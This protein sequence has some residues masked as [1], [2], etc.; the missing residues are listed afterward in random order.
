[1]LDRRAASLDVV[2]VQQAAAA[3][4]KTDIVTRHVIAVT[5]VTQFWPLHDASDNGRIRWPWMLS[6]SW[7]SV[8][9][10]P[11]WTA[12]SRK[13]AHSAARS[14]SA[15]LGLYVPTRATILSKCAVQNEKPD[16]ARDPFVFEEQTEDYASVI[17]ESPVRP[18][19]TL[20]LIQA[21]LAPLLPQPSPGDVSIFEDPSGS[22]YNTLT[23]SKRYT[24]SSLIETLSHLVHAKKFGEAYDFLMEIQSSGIAIPNSHLWELPAQ[25]AIISGPSLG[26]EAQIS[27]FT[28]W[29]SLIPPKHLGDPRRRFR[30][31]SKLIF[32]TQHANVPLAIQFSL[33]LA[34]KGYISTISDAIPFVMR[35]APPAVSVQFV[36]DLE[37]ADWDYKALISLGS[38]VPTRRQDALTRSHV[39]AP[40]VEAL[41]RS[42]YLNE[43]ISLL[44]GPDIPPFQL[45]DRTYYLLLSRLRQSNNPDAVKYITHVEKLRKDPAYSKPYDGQVAKNDYQPFEADIDIAL[46]KSVDLK[47][48]ECEVNPHSES[49]IGDALAPELRSLIDAVQSPSTFPTTV[50]LV[51]FIKSYFDT[52]R[53]AAIIRLRRLALQAHVTCA[54][55]FLQAEITYYLTD[56]PPILA[57]KTFADH[58]F[59]SGVP[60]DEVIDALKGSENWPSRDGDDHEHPAYAAMQT[61]AMRKIWPTPAI[62]DLVWQAL[63][64]LAPTDEAVEKLY[65]TLLRFLA[66][67]ADSRLSDTSF[68]RSPYYPTV[69]MAPAVFTPFIQRLIS[70]EHPHR[71]PEFVRDMVRFGIEPNVYHFTQIAGFYASTGDAQ[72]AFIIMDMMDTRYPLHKPEQMTAKR[73]RGTRKGEHL[74]RPDVIFYTSIMRGF[75]QAKSLANALEV[76]RRFKK[77]FV[78]LP[79]QHAPLDEVYADLRRLQQDVQDQVRHA[80]PFTVL[81]TPS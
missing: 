34:S 44:P 15:T 60:Q 1:M 19:S 55:G 73:L 54:T 17:R 40:A 39:R 69:K 47:V 71:V 16:I 76:D 13:I 23:A 14:T 77:R 62:S 72:R 65:Q 22:D 78:Y 21:T 66:V 26:M 61:K 48:L 31:T 80:S 36:K 75:V 38:E 41:A 51:P 33:M 64:K 18:P 46:S 32:Q 35:F 58:L 67:N 7:H 30:R 45:P 81:G 6:A 52:G 5:N 59:L 8:G 50:K 12:I 43:A 28:T 42:N 27:R 25:A 37:K 4:A 9:H 56:G 29:F 57:I 3:D 63:V 74:L 10:Q 53:S 20:S 68:L 11:R 49:Y 70:E 79:G 2:V 24:P